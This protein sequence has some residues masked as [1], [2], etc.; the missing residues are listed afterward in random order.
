MVVSRFVSDANRANEHKAC[1]PVK[2]LQPARGM[3]HHYTDVN[4]E[5]HGHLV[6]AW[7]AP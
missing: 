3:L 5:A 2:S 7:S 4:W 6:T 1:L